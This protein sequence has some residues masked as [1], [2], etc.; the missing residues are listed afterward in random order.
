MEPF[1][2]STTCSRENRLYKQHQKNKQTPKNSTSAFMSTFVDCD[3]LVWFESGFHT[4]K[5]SSLIQIESIQT[6]FEP[7][8]FEI[9]AGFRTEK[10]SLESNL[11][12]FEFEWTNFELNWFDLF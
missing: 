9:E 1:K 2:N 5:S 3:A 10:K 6:N 12:Q 4:G 8:W 7:I 11:T